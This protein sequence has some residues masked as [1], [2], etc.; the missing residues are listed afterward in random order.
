MAADQ[1]P[2]DKGKVTGG[3]P[4]QGEI[5]GSAHTDPKS[6]LEQKAKK[7]NTKR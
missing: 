3:I 5:T 2:E 7:S 4:P 6:E 1:S